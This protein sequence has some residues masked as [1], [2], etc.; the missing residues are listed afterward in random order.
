M[1]NAIKKKLRGLFFA[2]VRAFFQIQLSKSL[3]KCQFP[4]TLFY[5][6]LMSIVSWFKIFIKPNE[7][8]VVFI[9][10]LFKICQS[11]E[12]FWP[13]TSICKI[14]VDM[15]EEVLKQLNRNKTIPSKLTMM[16]HLDSLQNSDSLLVLND[17]LYYQLT[18]WEYS[19]LLS[20]ESYCPFL[21]F[22]RSLRNYNR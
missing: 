12:K 7:L 13:N 16:I 9:L 3:F 22:D 2:F 4:I 19:K 1:W 18:F 17:M 20:Y 15:F 11:F 6:I 14:V 8:K 5:N 10:N 21:Y